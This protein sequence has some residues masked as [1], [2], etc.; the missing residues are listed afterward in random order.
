LA[1][2]EVADSSC[3]FDVRRKV[4]IYEQFGLPET[5]VVDLVESCIRV[6]RDPSGAVYREQMES[7]SLDRLRDRRRRE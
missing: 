3:D 6:F 7:Y 1:L 4:P 5:W 2:I